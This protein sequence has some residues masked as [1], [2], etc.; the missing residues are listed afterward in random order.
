VNGQFCFQGHSYDYFNHDYNVTWNNERTVEVPIFWEIV[1]TNQEKRILEFGNVLSHYFK[2]THDIL[3]KYEMASG[4]INQDVLEFNPLTR[5]DLI[6]SISTLEHVGWDEDTYSGSGKTGQS[7]RD[8]G[9]PLVAMDILRR[10]LADGGKMVVS[11]PLGYNT[12][13][14]QLLANG[15]LQF[16]ECLAMKRISGNN[17]WVEAGWTE[18]LGAGYNSPFPHASAIIIGSISQKGD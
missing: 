6:I 12:Y 7:S 13:L 9:A 18:V 15:R 3:D 14:D 4:V 17:E 10:C 11:M 2:V 1:S 5:Y 8:P 16:D